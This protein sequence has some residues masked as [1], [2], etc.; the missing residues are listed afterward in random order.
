MKL[1]AKVSA[2]LIVSTLSLFSSP[3]HSQIKPEHLQIVTPNDRVTWLVGETKTISWTMGTKDA[4]ATKIQILLSRQAG[5][6]A[7][8]PLASV[9]KDSTKWDW[10]IPSDKTG[11]Y[12]LKILAISDSVHVDSVLYKF[13]I[14]IKD[15]I[16][17]PDKIRHLFDTPDTSLGKT[18]YKGLG[19]N[20]GVNFDLLEGLNSSSLYGELRILEPYLI[21]I[22]F[23][24]TRTTLGLSMGLRESRS[25]IGTSTQSLTQRVSL[26]DTVELIPVPYKLTSTVKISTLEAFMYFPS[27]ILYED[28]PGQNPQKLAF[29]LHAGFEFFNRRIERSYTPITPDTSLKNPGAAKDT[30]VFSPLFNTTTNFNFVFI[31]SI[32][33]DIFWET[34]SFFLQVGGGFAFLKHPTP[35]GG[36]VRTNIVANLYI[37]ELAGTMVG[38]RYWSW[39][40]SGDII[41]QTLPPPQILPSSLPTF[42]HPGEF[43][44]YIVKFF[45]MKKFGEI[46][47]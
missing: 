18:W 15:S 31:G 42:D 3:T 11:L 1:P 9:P 28:D 6:T 34:N 45:S 13:T 32:G 10:K 22:N 5:D 35:E 12:T 38:F 46:F 23:C 26:K 27:L 44:F 20:L 40:A 8:K 29:T 33:G 39:R 14:E 19:F 36:S 7:F 16:S 17:L 4:A 47:K 43:E 30:A 25:Y 2:S 24:S 21:P 37:K 41:D